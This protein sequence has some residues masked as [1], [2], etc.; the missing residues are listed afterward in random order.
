ML[1][2]GEAFHVEGDTAVTFAQRKCIDQRL[3][4]GVENRTIIRGSIV[5]DRAGTVLRDAAAAGGR[6]AHPRVQ[7]VQRPARHENDQA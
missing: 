4:Q 5:A 3:Q 6:D 2:R 7:D 1:T